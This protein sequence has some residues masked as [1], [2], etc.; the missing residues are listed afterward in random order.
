MDIVSNQFALPGSEPFRRSRAT[1]RGEPTT[2]TE[3]YHR[4]YCGW[5][6]E[7]LANTS[8]ILELHAAKGAF[9]GNKANACLVTAGKRTLDVVFSY[10]KKLRQ[11]QGWTPSL[12][13]LG[14]CFVFTDTE[15]A[16]VIIDTAR[17]SEIK[18]NIGELSLLFAI[19]DEWD[20]EDPIYLHL[21]ELAKVLKAAKKKAAA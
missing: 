15:I 21:G 2:L 4:G 17:T 9:F 18:N 12:V 8:N 10:Q 7:E 14:L 1:F 13:Y 11:G 3:Y 5:T 19:I 20:E 6:A 16:T